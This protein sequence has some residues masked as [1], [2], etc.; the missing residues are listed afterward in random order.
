M[1]QPYCSV[2]PKSAL[3][4]VSAPGLPAG[5]RRPAMRHKSRRAAL[6]VAASTVI[7][8]AAIAL[9]GPVPTA[10]AAPAASRAATPAARQLT[11]VIRRTSGG[12]P[13]ILARNWTDLGFGYG[14]AFAQDNLCTMA[15]DYVTVEGQRSR[16]F[17]PGASYLQR[18]TGTA[19]TNLDSDLFFRQIID[20]HVIRRLT[21]GLSPQVRQIEAGYVRGYNHYLASVGGSRGVPDP[22][23]RG[24]AW[25]K[26]ITLPDSYLRFYQ[27]MLLMGEG[28]FI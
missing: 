7:A 5:Q 9:T 18:A 17:G 19:T 12:I 23:C 16:Y 4:S 22:A 14:Y 11:A 24:R 2:L 6:A 10:A 13:H 27:L 21:R 26:P 25:V 20:S 28:V 1:S 15:D 8:S 3:S